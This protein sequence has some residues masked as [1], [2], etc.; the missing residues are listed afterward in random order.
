[1]S[2]HELT[3][4][5]KRVDR[6]SLANIVFYFFRKDDIPPLKKL[7]IRADVPEEEKY[8]FITVGKGYVGVS[9]ESETIQDGGDK[10]IIDPCFSLP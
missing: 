3:S 5:W 10:V 6:D 1:M 9:G 2:F 4:S 7:A 8:E